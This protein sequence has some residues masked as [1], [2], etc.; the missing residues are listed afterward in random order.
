M[1]KHVFLHV[2]KSVKTCLKKQVKTIR[3][4]ISGSDTNRF[5]CDDIITKNH[6]RNRAVASC[7]GFAETFGSTNPAV[8]WDFDSKRL[9]LG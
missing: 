8:A 9:R 7:A 2:S 6:P 5:R 4:Y 3:W 1:L